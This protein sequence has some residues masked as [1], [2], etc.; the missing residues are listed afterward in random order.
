MTMSPDRRQFT[1]QLA[2][3]AA[4]A[5]LGTSSRP[6]LAQ[7]AP[8]AGKEYLRMTPPVAVS[9]GGKIEVIE[10]F[11]YGCP[12]CYALEPEIEP[13]AAK[14]PADVHFRLVPY[15]FGQGPDTPRGVHKRIYYVWESLGLLGTMHRKTFDYMN[16]DRRSI[17]N[18]DDMLKFCAANGVDAAKVRDAWNS[19]GIETKLRQGGQLCDQYNIHSTPVLAIHGRFETEPSMV[20]S[21]SPG[22]SEQALGQ[23]TL[24]VADYLINVVR[25]G[26]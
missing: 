18:L 11:W 9:A 7:G 13:W 16:R 25:K 3:A 12:H 6:A 22:L 19:F 8:A 21:S 4:L 14:L 24:A 26:G 15:D 10:F 23:K 1:L 2:S 5:A 17:N 20:G